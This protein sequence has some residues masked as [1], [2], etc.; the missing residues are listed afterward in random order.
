MT[1]IRKKPLI[2]ER[3]LLIGDRRI[4]QSVLEELSDDLL[5]VFMREPDPALWP[6]QMAHLVQYLSA[7]ERIG[8]SVSKILVR[9]DGLVKPAIDTWAFAAWQDFAAGESLTGEQSRILIQAMVRHLELM[10]REALE[11]SSG[12]ED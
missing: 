11:R 7:E 10:V 3:V 1:H 5:Q 2:A 12:T 4:P 8:Y 6:D 9:H